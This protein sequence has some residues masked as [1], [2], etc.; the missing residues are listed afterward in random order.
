MKIH[1]QTSAEQEIFDFSFSLLYQGEN[2]PITISHLHWHEYVEI[3]LCV[4]KGHIFTVEDS[5]IELNKGEILV[6]GPNSVHSSFRPSQFV[7]KQYVIRFLPSLLL[8]SPSKIIK[9]NANIF[10]EYASPYNHHIISNQNLYNT[11]SEY[12][13]KIYNLDKETSSNAL[14]VQA[15]L[16]MLIHSFLQ[17]KEIAQTIQPISRKYSQTIASIKSTAT[18]IQTHYEEKISLEEMAKKAN[19]SYSYYSQLFKDIIGKSFSEF[20]NTVRIAAAEELLLKT[21]LSMKEIAE[22]VGICPQS[23][24]N[25]TY[26]KIRGCSPKEFKEKYYLPKQ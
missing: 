5:T 23:S 14:L 22:T 26:K 10:L 15:Y 2:D 19:V 25:H 4:D 8:S 9:Q 18:Y 13:S 3:I 17:S 12:A 11:C 24:F 16:L 21:N 7:G 1:H 20:L 6:I